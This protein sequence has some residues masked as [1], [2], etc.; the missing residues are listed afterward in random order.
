MI[1]IKLHIN[2]LNKDDIPFVLNKQKEY[3]F[4]FRKMYKQYHLLND[5]EFTNHLINKYHLSKY[6]FN[7]LKIDVK[8]KISQIKTQK[9]KL[10]EEIIEISNDIKELNKKDI[11]SKK[12]RRKLFKLNK[13]LDYKNSRLSKDITFGGLNNLR[14]LSFLHNNKELNKNKISEVKKKYNE[15][16]LLPLNYVGSANDKHSN[17]YFLFYFNENRVVYKPHS[18]KKIELTYKTSK[19]YDDL[20]QKLDVIKDDKLLPISVKLTTKY[21]YITFDNELLHGYG[22]DIDNYKKDIIGISDKD[23]KKNVAIKWKKEQTQ[24]K[25]DNKLENRYCGIDLN[26]DY[27]GISIIDKVGDDIKIIDKFCYDLSKLTK[28][29]GKSS[30]NKLSKYYNNKLKYEISCIYRDLFKILNHYKVSHFVMEDLSFK[31]KNINENGKE[32][33]RKTKNIWNREFQTNLINKYCENTGIIKVEINPLYTS[34]IGNITYNSFDPVNASI[35][36]CRRG[37]NKYIK[38]SGLY[39]KLTNTIIDTVVNRFNESIPDV[40]CI[41]YCSTWVELYK[42]LTKT[43]IKYRWQLNDIS[44]NCFSKNNIKSRVN[45]LTF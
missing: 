23:E 14:K 4:A 6:E 26:P 2:Y 25:L 24:R 38:G 1:T 29:S 20:L 40:Q 37:I 15:N 27:I 43:G 10:E 41:Q 32:F 28:K 19:K 3:S 5:K 33:N 36:I 39:P 21:I 30:N 22:F 9:T 16:R 7:C 45:L 42:L 35:E 18:G 13:K 11:L 12:E 34:F 31:D 8:T 17:R 44:F